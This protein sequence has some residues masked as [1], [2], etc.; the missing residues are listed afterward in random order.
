MT[1]MLLPANQ[2]NSVSVPAKVTP[3]TI[4]V[5]Y[6]YKHQRG[7]RSIVLYHNASPTLPCQ[8]V[9]GAFRQEGITQGASRGERLKRSVLGYLDKSRSP[10]LPRDQTEQPTG[11][12]R[13]PRNVTL[14][15]LR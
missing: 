11:R 14:R 15:R 9:N 13:N 7:L 3:F 2:R 10:L 6:V 12:R 1:W 4:R 8:Q 5:A